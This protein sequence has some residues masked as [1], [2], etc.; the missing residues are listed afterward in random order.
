MK[1]FFALLL[2]AS[3]APHAFAHGTGGDHLARSL[4]ATCANCHGT[5]G[6]SVGKVAQLAGKPAQETIGKLTEFKE[7]KRPA[8]IMHQIAKGFTDEQI[9]LLADYFAAQK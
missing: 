3:T 7:G 6:R 9:K 2:G 1:L 8:T 5:D 4:A